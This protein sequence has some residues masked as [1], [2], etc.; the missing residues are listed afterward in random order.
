MNFVMWINFF[1]KQ[2]VENSP[3]DSIIKKL[4]TESS[5]LQQDNKSNIYLEVNG[6]RSSTKQTRRIDIRIRYFYI[7]DKVRR[8]DSVSS[9]GGNGQ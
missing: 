3:L 7:T 2:Q 8:G 4:G 6:K 5:V 9:Y 1:I